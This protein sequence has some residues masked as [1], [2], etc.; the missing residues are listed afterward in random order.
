MES[1]S[2]LAHVALVIPLAMLGLFLR[3]DLNKGGLGPD[4][5]AVLGYGLLAAV[6]YATYLLCLRCLQLDHSPFSTMAHLTATA[7]VCVAIRGGGRER[8]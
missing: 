3:V 5:L 1:A 8:L 2:D 4:Y 7:L 6:A